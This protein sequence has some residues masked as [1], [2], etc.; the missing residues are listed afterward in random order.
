MW[1][2]VD[3][4]VYI[5][6]EHRED[7]RII[8]S[9]FFKD[10]QIPLEKIIRFSAVKRDSPILGCVESHMKVLRMAK[11]NKWKNVLVLEDDLEVVDFEQSYKKL[12]ELA[13]LPKWDVIMLTGWYYTYDLPRI[14]SAGNTGG[15]LVNGEY[16]DTLLQNRTESVN[17][18]KNFFGFSKSKLM[19]SADVYWAKLQK[20]DVWYGIEPCLCRQVDGFSDIGGKIVESS[21]IMGIYDDKIHKS[22]YK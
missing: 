6:L 11:D 17:G 22:V 10:T 12:E 2:F 16:I 15:Y 9:K 5:N 20:K 8:M 3:K 1:E 4:V 18:F 7:R 19:Y 21:K 13:R 14:Y